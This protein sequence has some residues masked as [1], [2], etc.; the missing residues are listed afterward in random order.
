MNN[1]GKI[2]ANVMKNKTE[3]END[4]HRNRNSHAN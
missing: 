1:T 3:T 4:T 2:Q